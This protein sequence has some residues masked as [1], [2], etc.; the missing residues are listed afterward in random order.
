MLIYWQKSQRQKNKI[1]A[2]LNP[3]ICDAP[4]RSMNLKPGL[5]IKTRLG[6]GSRR[7]AGSDH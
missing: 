1:Q 6:A 7:I 4:G 5:H 3:R 2:A